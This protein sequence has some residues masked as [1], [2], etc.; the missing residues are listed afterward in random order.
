MGE[1]IRE[2]LKN[3]HSSKN[4]VARIQTSTLK[5]GIRCNDVTK[6]FKKEYDIDPVLSICKGAKVQICGKNFEPGWGS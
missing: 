5:N 1:H 3:Q 4:S 6:C 2:K